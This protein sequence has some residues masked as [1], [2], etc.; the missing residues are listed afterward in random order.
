MTFPLLG[1]K[2][3][4]ERAYAHLAELQQ[5]ESNFF[6][7]NVPSLVYE[8]DTERGCKLA[9]LKL[10]ACSPEIIHVLAG[11]LIYQLRSALDQIA[12]AL[13][14]MSASKPNIKNVY[15]PC[16][17]SVASYEKSCKKC[18]AGFDDDLIVKIKSTQ[19]YNGGD[20]TL[21]AVFRMANID[22]HLE[23]IPVG[24]SGNV[25]GISNFIVNGGG[26]IIDGRMV[27]LREGIVI[28][29]L[30]PEG[31][32]APKGPDS[33][34][35]VAGQ[36]VLGDVSIYEGQPVVPFLSKLTDKTRDVYN[37]LATHCEA[38]GRC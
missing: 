4:I 5:A 14:K 38:T 35:T 9:K 31:T 20:D 19:A 3:K 2:L 25:S 29:E 12:V 30:S 10:D 18:L 37:T 23:I 27:S 21:R 17:D 7:S 28:S 1:P 15:F 16:D 24:A 11:E 34:I 36:L 6:S 26:L 22:K 32:I 8:E 33:R 13:A